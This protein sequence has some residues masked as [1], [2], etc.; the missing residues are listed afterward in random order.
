MVK[1]KFV[2]RGNSL[3]LRISEGKQRFYKSVHHLLV[4]SPNLEKHWNSDKGRFSGYAVSYAEN[5]KA[6]EDFK[7]IY[8][9]RIIEHPELNAKQIAMYYNVIKQPLALDDT[10]QNI[11]QEEVSCNL[12]EKFLEIVIQREKAKQGCNFETY[13]N[14]LNKCRKVLAGF[15][16]LTFQSLNYDSCIGIANVF[17]QYKGYVN[18][19]KTFRSLLGRAHKDNNVTF[20]LSQIGD[21]K[22]ADYNPNKYNVNIKKPDVLTSEQLKAFLNI[23]VSKMTPSYQNRK[24]VELYYDFSVFMF[25][26][27]FAPCDVI[28]L[29]YKNITNNNTLVIKRKK[30]HHQLETPISPVMEAI[31]NK[32]RGQTKNDYVFPILDDEKEKQYKK[33]DYLFKKFDEKI[34]GWLKSVGKELGL[35]YNLYAYVFRHTAITVA[36]DSGLPISYVALAAGTSIKMIQEH[37]YNGDNPMNQQRLQMAFMQAAKS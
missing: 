10:S 8:S 27:F 7:S 36:L 23:N 34:N 21:F 18:I 15:S 32:Y 33:K 4:G 3:V 12:I 24:N 25:H 16:S 20:N 28:K 30:T 5:N 1:L 19:T 29:K 31:T 11:P 2:I 35:E 22:F 14:L 37:Y 6:L 13:H 17:A 9:K 26:S